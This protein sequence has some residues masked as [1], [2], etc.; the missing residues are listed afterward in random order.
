M[1]ASNLAERASEMSFV[2]SL[3]VDS[4]IRPENKVALR[5]QLA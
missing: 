1:Q 4:V 2:P 3:K 5:C